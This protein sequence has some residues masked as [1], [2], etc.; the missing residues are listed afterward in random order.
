[1]IEKKIPKLNFFQNIQRSLGW[2]AIKEPSVPFGIK[3]NKLSFCLFL[4]YHQKSQFL[5]MLSVRIHLYFFYE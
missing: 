3:I 4:I 5:S 2:F 1:M